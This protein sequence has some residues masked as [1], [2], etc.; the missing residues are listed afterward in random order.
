[1]YVI[2]YGSGSASVLT[3]GGTLLQTIS[4]LPSPEAI[5]VVK[6]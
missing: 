2:N 3:L 1:L 6:Q 5:S 4:G